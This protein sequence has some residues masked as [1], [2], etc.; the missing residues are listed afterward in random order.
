MNRIQRLEQAAKF[1]AEQEKKAA[2]ALTTSALRLEQA[3]AQLEVL[4]RFRSEY[5][6]RLNRGESSLSA[7]QLLELRAFLNRISCAIEE[8]E[9]LLGKLR[10]EHAALQAAWQQACCRRR[11]I[12]KVQAGWLYRERLAAEQKLQRELDDRAAARRKM[13]QVE[14]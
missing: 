11:G 4:R 12:E 13:G 7:G 9:T 2:S 5:L 6:V 1:A 8:Q 10:Q 3:Q 14:K